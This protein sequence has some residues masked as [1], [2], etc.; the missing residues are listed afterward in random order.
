MK[1]QIN[2]ARR[3]ALVG[4]FLGALA[5]APE[6]RAA[7]EA[8]AIKAGFLYNFAQFIEWPAEA[9]AGKNGPL[10]LALYGENPFG[11]DI[12]LLTRKQVRGRPIQVRVLA[13]GAPVPADCHMLFVPASQRDQAEGLIAALRGRPVVLVGEE[14]DFARRGGLLNFFIRGQRVGFEVNIQAARSNRLEVSSRLLK[15]AHIVETTRP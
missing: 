15:L 1:R 5:G 14:R 9:F 10:V 4:A 12:F 6:V 2:R 11:A 13:P 8:Y 3:L 7:D